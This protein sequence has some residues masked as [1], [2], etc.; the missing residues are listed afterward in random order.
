MG[1][2][3]VTQGQWKALIGKNPSFFTDDSATR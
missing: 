1:A 2:A 3:E